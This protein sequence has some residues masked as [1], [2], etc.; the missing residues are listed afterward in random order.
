MA[1][2]RPYYP[3]A[4]ISTIDTLAKCL[5]VSPK[6][7]L[8]LAAD[9]ENSYT[10]FEINS[11]PNIV[12]NKSTSSKPAP[13]AK[14]RVVYEP[15]YNLKKI[16]KR[17]NSRIFEHILFP[18]YLQ[19]G[20]RD[21][22]SPRDHVNNSLIH[23]GSAILI[24]L[25]IRNFYDNIKRE[26]VFDIF[27]NFLRFPDDVSKVLTD[28]VTL[29]GKVPQGACTSSYIANLVFH[30]TEYSVVNYFRS[31][32]I[33]YS[34]LLD[35]V[36]LSSNKLISQEKI[37]QSILKVSA[38]FKRHKLRIHPHK[39]KIE[40]SSDSRS[41]FKVTGVW[42]AHGIPKVRRNERDQTRHKVYIC[43][44][45]FLK[46]PT[47]DEYHALWNQTSAKV[48]TMTRLKHSQAPLL[49]DRLSKILPLFSEARKTQIKF[50]FKKIMK[51]DA[52]ESNSLGFSTTYHKLIHSLGI[53]SRTDKTLSR[54]YRRSM[55]EKFPVVHSKANH[56]EL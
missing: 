29:R 53:L 34:R 46:D 49:R 26:S 11:K 52:S 22:D 50:E 16:Q 24:S 27:K 3:H 33:K 6:L 47:S 44:K 41:Q 4:P 15:K 45:E 40:L 20:I 10:E 1:K 14:T 7:M 56:W 28:L 18:D 17:I 36:T 8:D 51:R 43:E 38:M 19:G 21:I 30:N 9:A 37:E 39:K 2:D 35:D 55:R 42:V 32:G 31:S 12:S 13:K 25:D 54:A 48:A 5:G 23:A